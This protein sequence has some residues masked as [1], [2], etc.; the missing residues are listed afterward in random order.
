MNIILLPPVFVVHDIEKSIHFYTTKL[1]FDLAF[2]G[3]D[4]AGIRHGKAVIHLT[5]GKPHMNDGGNG[6]AYILCDDVDGYFRSY[7][8]DG[9]EYLTEPTL[10]HGVKEFIIADPDGNRL[11]IG[12][13]VGDCVTD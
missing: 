4:Y 1:G 5:T 6:N 7:K 10:W 11:M 13:D 3:D 2:P 8:G 9:G 12:E